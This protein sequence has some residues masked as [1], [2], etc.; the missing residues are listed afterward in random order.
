MIERACLLV[1]SLHE[2]F[3]NVCQTMRVGLSYVLVRA[4]DMPTIAKWSDWYMR[5]VIQ[6]SLVTPSTNSNNLLLAADCWG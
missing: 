5:E 3:G 4:R 1:L 6:P 2:C